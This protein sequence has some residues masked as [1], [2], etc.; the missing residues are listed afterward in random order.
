M[1][2]NDE[3]ICFRGQS[4]DRWSLQSKLYR[5]LELD[6]KTNGISL[7]KFEKLDFV[8]QFNE[9]KEAIK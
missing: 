8:V 7:L 6:I 9:F 1:A 4:D 5:N 2:S 3:E